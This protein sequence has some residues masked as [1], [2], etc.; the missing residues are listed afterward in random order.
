MTISGSQRK[1]KS[2]LENFSI[3]EEDQIE[4]ILPTN[5]AIED[6][7][8]TSDEKSLDIDQ[9]IEQMIDQTPISD[10]EL[11]QNLDQNYET[12]ESVSITTDEKQKIERIVSKFECDVCQKS[13]SRRQTLE[14]HIRF[15]HGDE[16]DLK[17]HC[18]ICQRKFISEKKLKQHSISHLPPEEKMIH[19]CKYCDKKWVFLDFSN[20]L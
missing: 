14:E 5:D 7:F 20:F 15:K 19:P 10:N 16:K 13:Y 6:K 17:F 18:D 2:S 1:L 12:H 8:N 4:Y 9:E 11:D 3:K